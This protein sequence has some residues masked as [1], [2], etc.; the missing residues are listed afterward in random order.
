MR[1]LLLILSFGLINFGYSQQLHLNTNYMF[2]PF[3]VNPGAAGTCDKYIPVQ[4]NFRKQWV[5]FPGS[6]TTQSASCHAEVQESFG[7]GGVLYNDNSGPSRRT[8][9][10]VS[11]S[12]HLRLSG[13]KSKM[14]GFGLGIGFSQ[15]MIDVNKLDTYLPDDPTVLKGYNNQFMP[16]AN[17]GVY[18]QWKLNSY[19]GLSAH[20]LAQSKRDLFDFEK[21]VSNPLVRTYYLT[22][23]HTIMTDGD[24]HYKL[25]G[26]VQVIETGT[27]QFD[28]SST[29][30]YKNMYWFGLGY[31][32]LDACYAL[33]GIQIGHVKVGYAYDYTISQIGRY[34]SGS[35]EIFAELQLY[36]TP[37]G[38]GGKKWW[39]RNK[40]VA[41]KI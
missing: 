34:S 22:A 8:G 11:G 32:H 7:F 28:L 18:Y 14:I 21:N 16:D 38:P 41:P 31:R 20:N 25:A 4:V 24:I 9:I 6:P 39:K 30:V 23:G 2:N 26:L 33:A 17:F 29:A 13:D 27:F 10:N 3:L 15:H 12:Y 5:G 1:N 19:V 36:N 35:H 40:R 37:G